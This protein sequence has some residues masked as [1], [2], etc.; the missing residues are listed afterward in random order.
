VVLPREIR[1]VWKLLRARRKGLK[2][3]GDDVKDVTR[4]LM[5]SIHRALE[6]LATWLLCSRAS[7]QH[8]DNL[9]LIMLSFQPELVSPFASLFDLFM[10]FVVLSSSN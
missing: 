8:R 1:Y 7:C 9:S 6:D 3:R 10:A 4:D 2:V 5:I